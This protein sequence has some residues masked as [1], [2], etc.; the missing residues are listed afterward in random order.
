MLARLSGPSFAEK[1]VVLGVRHRNESAAQGI[2]SGLPVCSPADRPEREGHPSESWFSRLGGGHE[3]RHGSAS[4]CAL[5][6]LDRPAPPAGEGP[7]KR[8]SKKVRTGIDA[9]VSVDCK[10]IAEAAA[11]AGLTR[12]NPVPSPVDATHCPTPPRQGSAPSC[13][14]RRARRF[15]QGRV[16]RRESQRIKLHFRFRRHRAGHHPRPRREY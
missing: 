2:N 3:K 9:L 8:I 14:R 13:H 15:R 10:I 1:L 16:A 7:P 6:A 4:K 11:K 12:R 5:R